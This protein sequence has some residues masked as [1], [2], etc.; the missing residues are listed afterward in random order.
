[1]R[2]GNQRNLWS[3]HITEGH[4][5]PTS[6]STGKCAHFKRCLCCENS[7][8]E[9]GTDSAGLEDAEEFKKK[10]LFLRIKQEED[11]VKQ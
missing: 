1:M 2:L 5:K 8:L 11:F 6:A 4:G 7:E 10:S 3:H 9:G